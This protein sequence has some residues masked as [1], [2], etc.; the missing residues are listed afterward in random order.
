MNHIHLAAGDVA[1]TRRFYEQHFGF[2]KEHDH[3]EGIFLRDS[4]AFFAA[5]PDSVRIEVSWDSE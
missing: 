5:D 1:I 2:S 3:G 4:A